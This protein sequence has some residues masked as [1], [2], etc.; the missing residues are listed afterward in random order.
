MLIGGKSHLKI[1]LRCTIIADETDAHRPS[2]SK[3][4]V[5]RWTDG[6]TSRQTAKLGTI[7]WNYKDIS[8]IDWR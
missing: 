8:R 5:P 6:S 4:Q 2:A 1:L 7:L 3:T